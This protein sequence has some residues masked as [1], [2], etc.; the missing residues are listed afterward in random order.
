MVEV[1]GEER[2]E[3]V[4]TGWRGGQLRRVT[5]A[6]R[7]RDFEEV[8][9][10]TLGAFMLSLHL[11]PATTQAAQMDPCRAPLGAVSAARTSPCKP[12]PPPAPRPKPLRVNVRALA[13][14]QSGGH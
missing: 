9:G 10:K 12:G 14:T 6:S 8:V 7:L 2:E 13:L 1:G 3:G 4:N 11:E 5:K